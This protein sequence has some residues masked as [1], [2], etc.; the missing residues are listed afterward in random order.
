MPPG[1]WLSARAIRRVL[2]ATVYATLVAFWIVSEQRLEEAAGF[3][4]WVLSLPLAS[5]AFGLVAG[6]FWVLA[7]AILPALVTLAVVGGRMWR[8]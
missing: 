3:G 7:L 8:R 5:V 2:L 4:A 6:R 1:P